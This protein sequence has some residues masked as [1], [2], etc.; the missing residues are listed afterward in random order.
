[1]T[2]DKGLVHKGIVHQHFEEWCG[3][4]LRRRD[5]VGCRQKHI[6]IHLHA[7]VK[8]WCLRPS[9]QTVSWL[10]ASNSLQKL[11]HPI[12]LAPD[13]LARLIDYA[14]SA[15]TVSLSKTRRLQP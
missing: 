1:L 6:G 12:P 10:S 8:S 15:H 9:A 2:F 7:S 5:R 11:K 13:E 4:G 3:D 14:H